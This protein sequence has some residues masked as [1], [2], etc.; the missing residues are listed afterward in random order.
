M[1]SFP[2]FLSLLVGP[3]RNKFDVIAGNKKRQIQEG[4]MEKSIAARGEFLG[5]ILINQI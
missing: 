2:L 1:Q 5:K 4:G 3:T